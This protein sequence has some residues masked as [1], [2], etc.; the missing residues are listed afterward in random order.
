VG[1]SAGSA[2]QG[3]NSIAI[4]NSAGLNTQGS[5]AIAIGNLAGQTSQHA[6]SIVLNASGVALNTVTSGATYIAPMR[7]VTQTNF[8]GYNTSSKEVSYFDIQN[9]SFTSITTNSILV[10]NKMDFGNVSQILS[11]TF[12]AANNVSSATNVTGCAFANATFRSF[13]MYISTA[14]LSSGTNYYSQYTIEGLQTDSGWQISNSVLGNNTIL[15]FTI[16]S[17]GQIQYTSTNVTNWTSSTFKF[18]AVGMLI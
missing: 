15:T 16:T 6:N 9:Y 1:W 11:G 10:S 3:T 5:N 4:G 12:N 13:T 17:A 18:Y 14:V 2:F 7:N 8:V